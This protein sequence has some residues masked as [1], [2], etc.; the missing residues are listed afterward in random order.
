MN[1]S[2]D[3]K[4]YGGNLQ[5]YDVCKN[6]SDVCRNSSEVCQN[7]SDIGKNHSSI[8]LNC[9]DVDRNRSDVRKNRSDVCRNNSDV[10]GNCS[11]VCVNSSEACSES[12]SRKRRKSK[13]TRNTLELRVPVLRNYTGKNH[14]FRTVHEC[15]TAAKCRKKKDQLLRLAQKEDDNSLAVEALF[16]ESKK[17]SMKGFVSRRQRGRKSKA[18]VALAAAHGI[19]G[20]NG[21]NLTACSDRINGLVATNQMHSS[22]RKY[23]HPHVNN[24]RGLEVLASRHTLSGSVQYLVQFDYGLSG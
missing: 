23:F 15:N 11:D 6:R 12:S 8:G 24:G 18:V 20:I 10:G 3:Y 16:T 19:N 1:N 4:G 14:P 9:S 21:V 17:S 7:R 5:C 13:A 22:I 2:Q